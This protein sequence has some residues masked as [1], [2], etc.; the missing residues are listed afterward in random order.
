[1]RSEAVPVVHIE[2]EAALARR[3]AQRRIDQETRAASAARARAQ[4]IGAARRVHRGA[5]EIPAATPT[6]R[7]LRAEPHPTLAAR[8]ERAAPRYRGISSMPAVAPTHSGRPPLP[9][10]ERGSDPTRPAAP[11]PEAGRGE[12][13]HSGPGGAARRHGGR[14][15]G[16]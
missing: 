6:H 9:Y 12:M 3:E 14:V 13:E 4:G 8:L 7:S 15:P 11:R 2:R 1:M 16:F 5:A 10:C